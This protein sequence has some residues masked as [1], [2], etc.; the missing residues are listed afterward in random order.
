MK[1]F[2]EVAEDIVNKMEEGV[3]PNTQ[4]AKQKLYNKNWHWNI[5]LTLIFQGISGEQCPL[6]CLRWGNATPRLY[7]P[8]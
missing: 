5:I 7:A 6:K 8:V 2:K 3:I 1:S 4:S